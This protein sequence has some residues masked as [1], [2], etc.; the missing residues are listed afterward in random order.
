MDRQTLFY[1]T[2]PAED[3]GPTISLQQV[4]SGN[5]PNLILKR[6]LRYFLKTPQL[7]ESI[8]ILR[9]KWDYNTYIIKKTS[10]QKLNQRLK[11]YKMNFVS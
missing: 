3:G 4:T 7:K 10:N 6:M 9:L 2:V 11:T 5:T 8:T 1:K